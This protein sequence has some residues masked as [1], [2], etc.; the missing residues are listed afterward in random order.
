LLGRAERVDGWREWRRE[1]LAEM[2]ILAEGGIT[3]VASAD[4]VSKTL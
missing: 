4:A 1:E 3:S 2:L